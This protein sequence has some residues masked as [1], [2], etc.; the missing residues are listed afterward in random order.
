MAL[1]NLG[2]DRELKNLQRTYGAGI[3]H[4]FSRYE[5]IDFKVVAGRMS[6]VNAIINEFHES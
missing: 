3:Y 6:L 2:W 1:P 4:V 5:E